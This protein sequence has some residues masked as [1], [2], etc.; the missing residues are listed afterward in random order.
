MARLQGSHPNLLRIKA[1]L[2]ADADYTDPS[3]AIPGYAGTAGSLLAPVA[4][5]GS[6]DPSLAKAWAVVPRRNDG[7]VLTKIKIKVTF[8]TEATGAEVAGTFSATTFAIVPRDAR[9]GKGTSRPAVEWL[10]AVVDQPSMKPI[11]VDVAA[12]DAMGLIFTSITA[13]GADQV[14]VYVQEWV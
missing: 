6:S 2:T 5:D 8:R 10:G 4:A 13:V 7:S 14:F 1:G 3:V 11:I 9:E 12:F